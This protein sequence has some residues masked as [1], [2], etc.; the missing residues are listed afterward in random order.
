MTA[1]S[2]SRPL[3][4]DKS[5][6]VLGS[7]DWLSFKGDPSATFRDEQSFYVTLPEV[8]EDKFKEQL[9]RFDSVV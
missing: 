8:I 9:K 3:P 2:K 1:A 6:V 7:F 5:F 4:I